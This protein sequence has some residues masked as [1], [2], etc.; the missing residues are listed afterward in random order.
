MKRDATRK[1]L[2]LALRRELDADSPNMDR[3]AALTARLMETDPERVRFSIDAGHVRRLGAELIGRTDTA[4]AEL[5]KNAYDADATE[6]TLRFVNADEPGGSVPIEDNGS[7]MGGDDLVNGFMR[8]ST[9]HKIDEPLSPR[10]G[11]PRAGRKGI[12]RF[13]AQR[14]GN[15]LRITT[16]QD[17]ADRALRV[18][19]SWSQFRSGKEL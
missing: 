17:G 4:L 1:G 3:I 9:S 7:G 14:L 10:F 8:L 11:R 18:D 6:V 16:R 12:G 5:V 15:A 19:L 13:A 2:Q